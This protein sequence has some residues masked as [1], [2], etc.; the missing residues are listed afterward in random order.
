MMMEVEYNGIP[1]SNFGVYAK[2]LPTIPPAVKK[3]LLW[4]LP[5]GMELYICW[6][7]DMNL[8]RSRWIST[9]SERKNSGLTGGDR[10]RSGYLKGTAT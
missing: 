6:M 7:E 10:Y 3:L 8:L 5:G 1:G 4:R 2:N 9:G